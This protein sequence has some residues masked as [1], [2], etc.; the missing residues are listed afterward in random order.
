MEGEVWWIFQDERFVQG[1]QW[2]PE[3]MHQLLP[4]QNLTIFDESGAVLWQGLLQVRRRGWFGPKTV[5][6]AEVGE[7]RW[8]SWLEHQPPLRARLDHARTPGPK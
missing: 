1:D 4:G 5:I 8:Q 6:P 3:G 7:E 2:L